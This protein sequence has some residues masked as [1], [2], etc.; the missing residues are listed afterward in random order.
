[1]SNTTIVVLA[2]VAIVVV[3]AIAVYVWLWLRKR[4]RIDEMTPEERE[5][6]EAKRQRDQAIALSEKTLKTTVEAWT[7][8]VKMAEQSLAAAHSIGARPLGSFEKVRLFEDHVETPQGTFRF[9]NGAVEAVV[10]TAANLARVKE[11]V[12]SRADKQVFADFVS[13]TGR[14]EGAQA[15]YLVV[16]TPIFVTLIALGT[17]DEPD[18]R[19]FSLSVNGAAV[20]AAGHQASR[21]SAVARAQADLERV[22][23][24]KAAA[25]QSAQTEL[26]AVAVDTRRLDAATRAVEEAAVR[27]APPRSAPPE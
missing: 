17:G 8:P 1:M 4:R 6:Y 14:P 18:A 15:L 5:F 12:L 25:V 19:Q 21:E 10:D 9:E 11:A 7:A 20:S 24:D 23:A 27:S 26:E 3:A 16:E 22:L 13:R 2:I